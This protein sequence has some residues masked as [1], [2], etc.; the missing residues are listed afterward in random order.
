MNELLTPQNVQS[1][2]NSRFTDVTSNVEARL[3][4]DQVPEVRAGFVALGFRQIGFLGDNPI[5]GECVWV[6]EV[7]TDP[8]SE[9]F[10]T[11]TISPRD[12]L[13]FKPRIIPTSTLQTA[14]ADGSLVVTTTCPEYLRFLNHPKAGSYLEGLTETVPPDELWANHCQ[15][16]AE[17]SQERGSPPLRHETMKLRIEIAERC[18]A[19]SAFVARWVVL[20]VA[21][22]L[23]GFI[24]SLVGMMHRFGI[25]IQAWFGIPHALFIAAILAMAATWTLRS[26]LVRGWLGGEWLARQFPR[27]RP[28]PFGQALGVRRDG[29][30]GG[31]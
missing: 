14:L 4:A 16:V 19:I 9:A 26:Q 10:L 5:P 30:I 11:L 23:A 12:P 21:L 27:P 31:W 13:T 28:T 3:R 22:I 8:K 25:Q 29:N 20:S 15:R 2:L 17:I 6:H 18:T 7:L 24:S 1:K